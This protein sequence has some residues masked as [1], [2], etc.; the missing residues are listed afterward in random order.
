MS[1][2]PVV[3]WM[4]SCAL[5]GSWTVPALDASGLDGAPS[6]RELKPGGLYPRRK[7]YTPMPREA[8]FPE[9]SGRY[10]SRTPMA[11]DSR[12]ARFGKGDDMKVSDVMTRDVT[13]IA[14][15]DTIRDAAR[16]MAECD[17][18]ALPVGENDRLVGVIT[19]RDIAIRAVAE[20]KT[21]NTEVR[22]VMTPQVLYCYED[23]TVEHVAENMGEQ[24]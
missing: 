20:G 18:G 3:R 13:L 9:T 21:P 5:Q 10:A 22:E 7:D 12:A 15:S 6:W 17:A 11:G 4:A 1:V 16:S 14:A 24:Q 19:D 2:P 8:N 23:E